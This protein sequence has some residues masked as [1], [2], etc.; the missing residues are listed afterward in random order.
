MKLNENTP[1]EQADLV[2]DYAFDELAHADRRS[3]EQH[4][5]Q[6][7][8]C[9]G[10][11][12]RL[13]LTTAA[14]RVLPDLE[15]PR[16]IAFVSDKVFEQGWLAGFWNSAARLGFASA[17]VLAVGL[18]FA[19]WRRQPEVSATER[20]ASSR[21]AVIRADAIN[22]AAIHDAVDKAV[23]SAV[24]RVHAD[25]LQMTRAALAEVDRKYEQ[26]QQDMVVAMQ[27]GLE[28]L[29]KRY[30]TIARS[31]YSDPPTGR[32]TGVRQ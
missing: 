13:R 6:C 10:E 31:S 21:T 16:R 23:A 28:D 15:V 12:D 7:A 8:D 22:D 18:S 17:C 9:A 2:R 24:E 14:L 3:M 29:H 19:A 25:D 20:T 5:R 1:C 11:L 30:L 26:K 4:L 32:P 27:S